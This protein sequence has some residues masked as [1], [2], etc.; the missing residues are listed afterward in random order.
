MRVLVTGAEGFVAQHLVP[1]LQAKADTVVGTALNLASSVAHGTPRESLDVTDAA[2]CRQLLAQVRPTHVVH[3]AAVSSVPWSFAHPEETMRVNVEGARNLLEAALAVGVER[4]LLVGSAEEYGPND[5]RPLSELPVR[6][7]RPVSPYAASKVEV[8][9]MVERDPR[10]RSFAVRTRSFPH[11]GPGQRQGFFASDVA[12]QIARGASTGTQVVLRVGTLDTVRDYTDVRD[13]VRAYRLLLAHGVPGEVYN[14]CSGRRVKMRDLLD[15]F[16]RAARVPVTLE[17]DSAL[18]RPQE[19]PVL[20]GDP[21]RI[22]RRTG[23]QS[24]ISLRHTVTDILAWWQQQ[25]VIASLPADRQAA[26]QPPRASMPRT[27]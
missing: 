15:E 8:E 22:H 18:E 13:I 11:F 23:W 17:H 21:S 5:G 20:V 14:V 7:L 1:H 26:K 25:S 16:V 2:A 24:E 10:F 19:I 3:L 9:R 12:S 27:G 6:G 4:V